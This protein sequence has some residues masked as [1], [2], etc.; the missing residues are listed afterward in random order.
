MYF[1]V[2]VVEVGDGVGT[3]I[4]K[5]NESNVRCTDWVGGCQASVWIVGSLGHEHGEYVGARDDVQALSKD[6]EG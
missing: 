5:E 2:D 4:I 3:K 1:S 6:D